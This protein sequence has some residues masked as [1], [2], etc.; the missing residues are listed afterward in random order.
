MAWSYLFRKEIYIFYKSLSIV[1]TLSVGTLSVSQGKLLFFRNGS[2]RS[3]S[4]LIS[5]FLF[6]ENPL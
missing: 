5:H 6:F 2:E 1:G 4:L 3:A